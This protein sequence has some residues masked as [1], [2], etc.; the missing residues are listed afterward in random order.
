MTL[1][2]HQLLHSWLIPKMNAQYIVTYA[3]VENLR[4][5]RVFEKNGFTKV[6]V[7]QDDEY[8]VRGERRSLTMLEWRFQDDSSGEGYFS[9]KAVF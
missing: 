8:V 6:A 2:V 9:K 5:V 7:I 4:S 3:F 1:V